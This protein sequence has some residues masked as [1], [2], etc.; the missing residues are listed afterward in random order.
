MTTNETGTLQQEVEALEQE[1]M[2]K[3][4]ALTALR[5]RLPAVPV[6][7]DYVFTA[8]DGSTQPLSALFGQQN[9]LILIHN[10]GVRCQYCA[11]WSDGFN[12]VLKH[13]QNRAAFVV[14][15]PDPPATLGAQ[16]KLRGWDFPVYSHAGTSFSADMG[17]AE[18]DDESPGVS[19]FV[20][21]A[22]GSI[23]R[24]GRSL[25]GPGD[26]F[27]PIWHLFDLLPPGRDWDPKA[28][29]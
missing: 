1:I 2:A 12:G 18:G 26:D 8:P 11:L 24:V 17:M 5:R 20:K 29:Y 4:Q 16:A 19:T 23:Q 13:L 15:T 22:D 27:A 10:M 25:F 28:S 6:T 21:A 7:Q 3:K 9:E 14:V